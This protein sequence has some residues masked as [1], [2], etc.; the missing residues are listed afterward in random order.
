MSL[1]IDTARCNRA[2]RCMFSGGSSSSSSSGGG[3]GSGSSSNS[4][5]SSS[6]S[7]S[8]SNSRQLY[9]NIVIHRCSNMLLFKMKVRGPPLLLVPTWCHIT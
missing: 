2:P 3:G 4:N 5:R 8:N 9:V 1:Q 7:S 6:S